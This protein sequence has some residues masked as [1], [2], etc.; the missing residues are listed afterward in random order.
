MV[1]YNA[2]TVNLYQNGALVAQ[3]S[4]PEDSASNLLANEKWMVGGSNPISRDY[5]DGKIDDLR[6]YNTALLDIDINDTYNDDITGTLPAGYVNQ[7][8]YD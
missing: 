5:F 6:F 3:D 7:I 1:D 4:L 2:S 8:L